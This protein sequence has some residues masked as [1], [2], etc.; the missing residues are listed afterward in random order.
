MAREFNGTDQALVASSVDLSGASNVVT[1]SFWIWAATYPEDTQIIFE[2]SP[3]I[4]GVTTGFSVLLTAN[5]PPFTVIMIGDVGTNRAF[6]T[7]PT[8]STWVHVVAIFDK[9]Q[10][11]NAE[12]ALYFDGSVQTPTTY[13][14]VANNTNGFAVDELNFMSR[15]SASLWRSGRLADVAVWNVRLGGTD[16]TSLASGTLPSA[17]QVSNLK[18]YW[19]LCG[20]ASPEPDSD[21]GHDATLVG[22]PTQVDH[23]ATISGSCAPAI[24]PLSA[25][26]IFL[27]P[28]RVAG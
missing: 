28:R 6:F 9:T 25:N 15:N 4:N 11:G 13:T 8:T 10:A 26:G 23:P 12:V 18:G 19:K 5:T 21:E 2:F 14:D 7:A 27:I 20:V 17:I 1:L 24:T 16:I 3:D 22:T